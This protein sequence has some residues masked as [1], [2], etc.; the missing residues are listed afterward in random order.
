MGALGAAA[1]LPDGAPAWGYVYRQWPKALE[2]EAELRTITPTLRL[3][4]A[5]EHGWEPGLWLAS[6]L[7]RPEPEHARR[8]LVGFLVPSPLRSAPER[9][10]VG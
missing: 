8:G 3:R 9:L 10:G 4:W 6:D 2:G 1:L 5:A 7:V